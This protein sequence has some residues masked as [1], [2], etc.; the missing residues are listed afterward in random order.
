MAAFY[1]LL[2]FVVA[3]ALR[4]VS[5]RTNALLA[6][7]EVVDTIA[8][9]AAQEAN[10]VKAGD[11]AVTIMVRQ[12]RAMD[13]AKRVERVVTRHS[14]WDARETMLRHW[15]NGI[16][17]LAG[18]KLP[19]FA[20]VVDATLAAGAALH[21]NGIPLQPLLQSLLASLGRVPAL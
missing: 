1:C 21:F 12:L 10:R 13:A 9:T 18:R 15:R 7:H 2:R 16:A 6:K 4:F 20:G 5:W 17:K 3:V 14:K 19:Y 8:D 11:S